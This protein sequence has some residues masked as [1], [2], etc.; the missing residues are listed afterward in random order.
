M[1]EKQNNNKPLYK[2]SSA[3]EILDLHPRTLRNYEK[4]GL[5]KPQ[6][7]GQWR[8]YSKRDIAWIR[9]LFFMI[10]E[11]GINITSIARLLKYAPCWAIADCPTEKRQRCPVALA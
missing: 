8:Y 1:N 3:A 2:I 4:A 11:K 10:H 7:R 9:C 6:R 5:V